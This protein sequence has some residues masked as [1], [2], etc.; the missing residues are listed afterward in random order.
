MKIV[1]LGT[2]EFAVAPLKRILDSKKYEVIG[3]VTNR[4]KPVGRKQIITE[5]P[6]KKLAKEYGVPVFSYD[7]IRVEGVEDLKKLSP[8]IMITCAFGQIL[9]A[10]ILDIPKLGVYNIHASL[11][12]K[13]RG[14]SPINFALLNGEKETGVTV[15]KTDVGVDTGD[16]LLSEKIAIH[17]TDNAGDLFEKLSVLGADCIMKAL[18]IISTGKQILTPQDSE[19]ATY[20]KMIKKEDALIDWTDTAENIV[21]K[22]R[23]YNPSPVAYTEIDG[24]PLKVYRAE[25]SDGEGKMGEILSCGK[26]LEIGCGKGSVKILEIKKSG[27][28][29]MS[30]EDFLR[31]NRFTPGDLIG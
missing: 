4:D 26:C 24:T 3:V 17:D 31:G 6:V 8:D 30:A 22:I 7:K 5:C 9:S 27:G 11:L 1:Y 16:M 23:A 18:E 15:M 10:E 25:V 20:T 14:A 19:Q 21:N 29:R 28:N 12:P 2:P 13:Y